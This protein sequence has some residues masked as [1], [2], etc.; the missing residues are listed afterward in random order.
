VLFSHGFVYGCGEEEPLIL[1]T[2]GSERQQIALHAGWNWAS[3]NLDLT[4]SKGELNACIT[5]AQP[6]T[7]GDLIKNPSS[8]QFSTYAQTEDAF[9][10]TLSGLH[11]SQIYMI[12]TANGNTIRVSGEQLAEDSMR[13]SVRG[14]GQWSP[15]PCL[16]DQRISVTEAL[17]D[18][19][20]NASVGDIIKAHNRFATFSADRRW[21]GDLQALQPGEGYLFRRLAPST[22]TITFYKPKASSSPSRRTS[23]S[24]T[25]G[26]TNPAAATNM[27]MIARLELN[28]PSLA[29]QPIRVYVNNEL[30]AVAVPTPITNEQS[31]MSNDE[32]FYF[33]TIQSD[34]LGELRFECENGEQLTIINEQSPMSNEQS[35]I[36]PSYMEY[37]PD[38]HYG[39]LKSPVILR[40]AEETGVYKII[41]ENHVVI[42]RNN[43]RYDVTGKKL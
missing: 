33:I 29:D 15:L 23:L 38:A 8:R 40:P 19:Y 21:V 5:A 43:E 35:P 34:Q 25:T 17:A 30:A 11:F 6:W 20:Q 24:S 31:P 42:I 37:V 14:D 12:Y 13:I 18:Y 41:E 3:V 36:V 28:Q 16:F 10:G 1:T 32:V 27:T 22:E 26:Y 2:G 39:T 9:I 4:K 7:E